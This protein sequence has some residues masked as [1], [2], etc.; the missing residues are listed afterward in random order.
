MTY[1]DER[2]EDKDDTEEVCVLTRNINKS[3]ALYDILH[4][5]PQC[6][7]IAAMFQE[8]QNWSHDGCSDVQLP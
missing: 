6:Q 5:V 7:A 4:D 8:T 2:H 1:K 3:S